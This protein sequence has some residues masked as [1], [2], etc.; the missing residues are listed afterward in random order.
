MRFGFTAFDD[1]AILAQHRSFLSD[2]GN[3]PKAFLTDAFLLGSDTPSGTAVAEPSYVAGIFYRP[4]QTLSFMADV[5]LSRGGSGM[6]HLTNTLLLGAIG[7]L[8]FLFFRGFSIPSAVALPS[9]LLYCVH[10]LFV[11]SVAWIPA[12][13]DLLLVVFSLSSFLFLGRYLASARRGDLTLHWVSFSLA[14]FSKETAALLP[15]LFVL[16]YMAVRPRDAHP[17]RFLLPVALYGISGLVW[18]LLRSRALGS[19]PEQRGVGLMALLSNLRIIPE[20]LTKFILPFDLA[21]VP[22][23]AA[24]GTMTGILVIALLVGLAL[25]RKDGNSIARWF[26][27]CWFLFLLLPTMVYRNPYYDY[28]NHRFFLPLIGILLFL[29]LHVP[30]KWLE[31]NAARLSGGLTGLVVVFAGASAIASRSYADP[32]S[33]YDAVVAHNPTNAL[34]H[35]NRGNVKLSRGDLG[36]A[37]ADFTQAVTLDPTLAVAHYNCGN[38]YGSQGDLRSAIKAYDRD[39]ALNPGDARAYLNRGN[40]YDQLGEHALALRDYDRAVAL[41]PGDAFGYN[42]RGIAYAELGQFEKAVRDFDRAIELKPDFAEAFMNRGTT[43]R[44]RHRYQDA[45]RDFK[46]HEE[47]IGKR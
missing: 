2:V 24:F 17:K 39:L 36:G 35:N 40:A 1:D 8:L 29:Q 42:G 18:F 44:A 38:A 5:R 30:R 45:A 26:G 19:I 10:P 28:L 21:P 23:F 22:R 31:R 4:L 32:L 6:F 16:Y 15:A 3:A 46:R 9:A 41:N 27:L 11:S 13:G 37:I 47:L 43:N 7:S 34:M 12:R 20:A 25:R 14:L 33:F